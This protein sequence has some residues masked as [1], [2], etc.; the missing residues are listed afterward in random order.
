M[1]AKYYEIQAKC[2]DWEGWQIIE[3]AGSKARAEL[4][5]EGTINDYGSENVKVTEREADIISE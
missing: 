3:T 1:I 4:I 5:K 2:C